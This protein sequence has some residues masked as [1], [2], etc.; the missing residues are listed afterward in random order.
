MNCTYHSCEA[1]AVAIIALA[2]SDETVGE[3]LAH[4]YVWPYCAKHVVDWVNPHHMVGLAKEDAPNGGPFATVIMPLREEY[5]RS[6]E[7]K[8][9]Q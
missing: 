4:R 5:A 8:G 2:H 3:A 6:I 1:E 7:R 9:D